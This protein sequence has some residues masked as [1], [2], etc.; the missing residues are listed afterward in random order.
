MADGLDLNLT[1]AQLTA[2]EDQLGAKVVDLAAQVRANPDDEMTKLAY[3][4]AKE[5]LR[6][7]RAFWRGL[8]ELGGTRRPVIAE[9]GDD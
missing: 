2:L 4:V 6:N 3:G 1:P 7:L 5:D 9:D 8:G